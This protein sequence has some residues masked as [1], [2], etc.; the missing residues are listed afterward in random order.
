MQRWSVFTA[1]ALATVVMIGGHN[2]PQAQEQG[3]VEVAK[4]G[5]VSLPGLAKA[6]A[7][8]TTMEKKPNGPMHVEVLPSY[9]WLP[10]K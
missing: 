8:A 7:E 9:L 1:I 10:V 3:T 4:A 5:A 6:T 2:Q